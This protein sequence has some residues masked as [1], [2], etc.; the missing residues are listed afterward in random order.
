MTTKGLP[1]PPREKRRV[2]R[3]AVELGAGGTV[4]FEYGEFGKGFVHVLDDVSLRVVLGELDTISDFVEYLAAKERLVESGSRPTFA[5]EK[6]L[7]AVYLHAGR[8]FP[9]SANHW[10]VEADSWT[11]LEANDEWRQ[12]KRADQQS[13]LWD[14]L[15]E[16]LA[17]DLTFNPLG[18]G[19]TLSESEQVVRVMARETRFSRRILAANFSRFLELALAKKV[20]RAVPSPSAVSYVYLACDVG[21]DLELRKVVEWSFRCDAS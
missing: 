4:P 17:N 20:A 7:L 9:T 21:Q 1:L 2:H 18:P 6:D 12:R 15:I 5:N 19:T 14:K 11:T 8:R 10:R 16:L 3:V 13:Y